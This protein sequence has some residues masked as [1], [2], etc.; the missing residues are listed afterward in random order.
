MFGDFFIVMSSAN[1]IILVYDNQDIAKDPEANDMVV[2]VIMVEK[3]DGTI[4]CMDDVFG[5][6]APAKPERVIQTRKNPHEKVRK[7]NL[8]HMLNMIDACF[9]WKV[10][11]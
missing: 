1:Q 8:M 4:D 2:P 11:N 9:T 10:F 5:S 3:L 7:E 6:G